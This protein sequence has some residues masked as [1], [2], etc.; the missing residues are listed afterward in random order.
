MWAARGT[1]G[2]RKYIFDDLGASPADADQKRHQ[3]SREAQEAREQKSLEIA[4]ERNSQHTANIGGQGAAHLMDHGDLGDHDPGSLGP[5]YTAEQPYGWRHSGNPVQP[6]EYAEQ[7]Q[8]VHRHVNGERQIKQGETTQPVI[9]GEQQ[10]IV[11]A[12]AEPARQRATEKAE[13]PVAVSGPAPVTS[14]RPG[15][16]RQ[17]SDAYR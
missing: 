10:P 6:I 1:S 16:R 12:I 3:R 7:R 5:D 11:P 2:R 4:P 17:G 15:S 9:P 14:A 8:T 13:H